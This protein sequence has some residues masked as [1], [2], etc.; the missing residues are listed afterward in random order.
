MEL[1]VV[2][3]AKDFSNEAYANSWDMLAEETVTVKLQNIIA[4]AANIAVYKSALPWACV[5][6]VSLV[7]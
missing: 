7:F 1:L 5:Q 2:K 6:I 3:A 4:I